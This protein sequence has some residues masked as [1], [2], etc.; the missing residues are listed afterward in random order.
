MSSQLTSWWPGRLSPS[1][2]A[3]F[4]GGVSKT[5]FCRFMQKTLGQARLFQKQR[6]LKAL[7]RFKK[8]PHTRLPHA[9]PLHTKL[10]HTKL[11]YKS[12]LTQ[13]RLK[14]KQPLGLLQTIERTPR[15]GFEPATNRLTADRSTAELP[16]NAVSRGY[17]LAPPACKGSRR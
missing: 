1:R 15:A 2:W 7:N 16:R 13:S 3:F 17:L 9:K 10:L 4:L 14:K 11:L 6:R 8:L 12:R 5:Q